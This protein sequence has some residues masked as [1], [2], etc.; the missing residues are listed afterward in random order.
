MGYQ[1]MLV[2]LVEDIAL[3]KEEVEDT[4]LNPEG[5]EDKMHKEEVE[6]VPME[7]EPRHSSLVVHYQLDHLHY[8]V[9]MGRL[10]QADSEQDKSALLE[11]EGPVAQ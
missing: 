11:Q 8:T 7:L 2:A 9:G 5:V 6:V 4:G 3:H 10:Q 1:K